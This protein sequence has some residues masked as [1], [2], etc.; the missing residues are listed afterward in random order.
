MSVGETGFVTATTE[1]RVLGGVA[2]LRGNESVP[3]GGPKAQMLV[4][5]LVAHRHHCLSNARLVEALWGEMAPKSASSTV[6]SLI[7][8]LRATLAP[9]FSITFGPAGYQL[10]ILDGQI[11]SSRFESLLAQSRALEPERSL[12]VL[13]AALGLWRGPAF[14]PL[15]GAEEVR[16]EAVRLDELRLVATDEWAEASLRCGD[17]ARMVGELE[18]LVGLHP[19]RECY[20]RLL[21]LALH[22]TGRQAEALR[23][24]GEFRSILAEEVG[25]DLSPAMR[26]LEAQILSDDPTLLGERDGQ[27][28]PRATRI[29]AH[30]LLGA[31]SFIGRDPQLVSLAEALQQQPLITITGPGGV[32]KT[33]LAMRVAAN[34]IDDF[35]DGV[36][37]VEFA[38]L[39]DPARAA[40]VIAHALD[41]QLRQHRTIEETIEDH[42]ASTRTLLLLDN[43][44]H[45]TEAVAPL[46]DRL[47]S[48]C[49]GLRILATSRQSLGLAGEYLEVLAPL[50]VP[51]SGVDS[52]DEIRGCSA[53]ELFVTRAASTTPGFSVTDD[54]ALAVAEICRQLDGLPLALELAAARLRTMGVEA[55]AVRLSQRVEMIGQTQ[56]GAD[57]R[58]RTLH[59][60]VKWSHDLLEPEEQQVFEQLAV[61]AGGFDLVAAESVTVA[62][63]GESSV[64]GHI[65]SLV[66]KS[67]VVLVDQSLPRYKLLEPLREFGL[68]HLRE[69]GALEAAEDRHLEWFL[70]LAERGAVGL[71]S[72][73]EAA[74]SADLDRDY[75]NFRV[76]HLTAIRR[77]DADKALRLV[78]SLREFAFRRVNYEIT[79]WADSSSILEGA[80]GH[81]ELPTALA[82]VAYGFFVRGDMQTAIELAHRTLEIEG[83]SELSASGLPERV[84]ANAYFY[85]E[86]I[87]VAFHWMNR[88]LLS[89]RRADAGGRIAHDLFMLSVAHTSVGDGIRGAVLA[90]EAKAAGGVVGSATANALADYALGLALEVSEP[91]EALALLERSGSVGAKAGNRWIEAFA[92]TEVHSLRADN[93]ENLV[94]LAGYAD[95]IDTW[96]RGGDWANQWLSLKRVLIILAEL[97]AHEPAAVLYG[98]LT[99][100]GVARALPFI[101]AEAERLSQQVDHIRS[102]LGPAAFAKALGQG[103]SMRDRE[104]VS[105]VKQ[106]IESLA[107][108]AVDP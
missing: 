88:M 31:T 21:M 8:R 98:A 74:W 38:G 55:L 79:S 12:P 85:L 25:L 63:E 9:E 43:C 102:E 2:L 86:Q 35:A 90:G 1:L 75:E 56:R 107:D 32:G 108:E 89:S 76:A 94:A 100:V 82:V 68:D 97:G 73:E 34:T 4:S 51:A 80:E 39:R 37:V 105:F 87:D 64:V 15:G 54:N 6:Q 18:A 106:Q 61:F 27:G 7:S 58:Q 84:L 20:W 101:P 71:D 62:G 28:E 67:M 57:G 69:R 91:H 30:Q 33:R 53:V 95:V 44:E 66:D 47:R 96:Y 40:L 48:A 93:G 60:L 81:P 3:L 70:D 19:L 13:E 49:P 29:G 104:I 46:V 78:A 41:V 14:G 11:D 77:N 59:D 52:I 5:V 42:L 99:A 45:V 16:G 24:A 26:T 65:A 103:A 72:P 50:A 83:A 36:V 17:P 23:R 92:L 22:R 10:E